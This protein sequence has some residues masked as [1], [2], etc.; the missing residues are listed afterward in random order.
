MKL[1][2]YFALGQLDTSNLELSA[3]LM[4]IA[5]LATLAGAWLVRRMRPEVFYPFM[6]AM[7]LI[8]GAKLVHDGLTGGG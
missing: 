2:P 6:Y 3:I 5:P 1:I 8:V 4:P 7:V